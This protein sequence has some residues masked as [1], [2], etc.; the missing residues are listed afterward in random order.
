MLIHARKKLAQEQRVLQVVLLLSLLRGDP[1][2]LLLQDYIGNNEDLLPQDLIIGSSMAHALPPRLSGLAGLGEVHHKS[3]DRLLQEYQQDVLADLN[4]LGRY[5]NRPP[6]ADIH[7]Y[8]LN[9]H[10]SIPDP[11]SPDTPEHHH[12]GPDHPPNGPL[13][14]PPT[15]PSDDLTP[16]DLAL[17]EALWKQDVDLG[18]PR[19]LYEEELQVLQDGPGSKEKDKDHGKKPK[20]ETSLEEK[21]NDEAW[22]N[23]NFTIDSETGEHLLSEN[24]VQPVTPESNSPE[25]IPISLQDQAF[26]FN[27]TVDQLNIEFNLDEALKLVGLNCSETGETTGAENKCDWEKNSPSLSLDEDKILGCD[28][29]DSSYSGSSI[30]DSEVASINS[31]NDTLDDMIQA[32]HL[33]HTHPRALQ[34]HL[35]CKCEKHATERTNIICRPLNTAM[36]DGELCGYIF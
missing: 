28:I 8:L 23:F 24:S 14:L 19:E 35:F 22:S 21:H 20:G 16:E 30:E 25:F 18:V 11:P 9:A 27:D 2:S 6:P 10:T 13:I 5:G 15:P 36:G 33:H 3:M 32:S 26:S 7:A 1:G 29:K 12:Q 17:I 34:G 31:L 4:A